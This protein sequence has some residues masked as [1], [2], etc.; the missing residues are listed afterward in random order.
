MGLCSGHGH[1]VV[2]RELS[3]Y[4]QSLLAKLTVHT[5]VE[6]ARLLAGTE[7]GKS[8]CS[9]KSPDITLPSSSD[10]QGYQF[11]LAILATMSPVMYQQIARH[12]QA[13]RV[14]GTDRHRESVRERQRETERE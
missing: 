9:K 13:V 1:S 5:L 11:H 4:P 14:R 2:I 6:T 12:K 7:K 3:L 8:L 10:G